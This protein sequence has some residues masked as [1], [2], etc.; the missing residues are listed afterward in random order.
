MNKFPYKAE[1]QSIKSQHKRISSDMDK[2]ILKST[3][4]TS[5]D[6]LKFNFRSVRRVLEGSR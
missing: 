2:Q 4:L 1:K 6:T 5:T 3:Q